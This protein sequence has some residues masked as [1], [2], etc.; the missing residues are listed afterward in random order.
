VLRALEKA[1]NK[2][3]NDG[4]RGRDRD[5]TTPPHLAHLSVSAETPFG[6]DDFDFSMAATV[7]SDLPAMERVLL[8]RRLGRYCARL[9]ADNAPFTREGLR[10]AVTAP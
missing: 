2:L 1:G 5:R 9:Y 3:L 10:E 7:L 4:K 6:A 8:E